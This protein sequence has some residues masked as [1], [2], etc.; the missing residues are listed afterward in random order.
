[1]YGNILSDDDEAGAPRGSDEQ[2][3][4]SKKWNAISKK[5]TPRFHPDLAAGTAPRGEEQHTSSNS[6]EWN[7]FQQKLAPQLHSEPAAVVSG[8]GGVASSS[9]T[10]GD[11]VEARCGRGTEWHAGT[12]Q[13]VHTQSTGDGETVRIS[14]Y[15]ILCDDGDTEDLERAWIRHPHEGAARCDSSS[16][17][18]IAGFNPELGAGRSEDLPDGVL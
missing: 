16:K 9:F 4:S 12:I 8:G 11:R 6:K 3:I 18:E 17:K 5:S 10:V 2:W 13:A 14:K 1:L 7:A 15:S